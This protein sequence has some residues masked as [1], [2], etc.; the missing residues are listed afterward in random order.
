[1]CAVSRHDRARG[2]KQNAQVHPNRPGT[3]VLQIEPHHFVK[4]S[5]ASTLDLPKSSNAWF[6][7]HKTPKVP[8]FV[9]FDL[10]RNWR[11]GPHQRHL[12]LE[13]INKLRELVETG[14][15]KKF[16]DRRDSGVVR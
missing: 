15:A 8:I 12:A 16:A 1:M 11:T 14:A 4:S 3:R 5:P 10:I 6:H 7:R 2:F 13:H 9:A